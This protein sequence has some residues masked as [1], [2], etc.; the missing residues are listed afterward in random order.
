MPTVKKVI[1][2]GLVFDKFIDNGL[3]RNRQTIFEK[4]PIDSKDKIR[5]TVR[6]QY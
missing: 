5:E 1:I 4:L 2:E 3:V 6:F